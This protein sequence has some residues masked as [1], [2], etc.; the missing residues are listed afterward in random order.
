MAISC[1]FSVEGNLLVVNTSGVD[2]SLEEVQQ[3]GMAVIEK[4]IEQNCRQVLCVET[5]LEYRLGAIDLFKSAEYIAANAP[6]VAR[7]AIVCGD[8]FAGDISFWETVAVNRGLM[9][10]AF[11]NKSDALQ[12]INS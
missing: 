1:R 7:V 4:A 2:E 12:W 9:V 5:D 3:Y 11:Q 10:R 8:Q 6:H